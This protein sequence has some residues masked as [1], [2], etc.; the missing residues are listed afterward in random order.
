MRLSSNF[1]TAITEPSHFFGRGALLK[2]V[3]ADPFRVRIL[4]GGRRV[5]KTSTLRA[6]EWTMLD[7]DVNQQARAFPVFIDLKVEQPQNLDNFRYLLIVRLREALKKWRQIPGQFFRDKYREFL[8]QISAAELTV[9]FPLTISTKINVINPDNNQKLENDDFRNAFLQTID[10]LRKFKF[11]GV[12]FLIDEAEFVVS[13][14]WANDAW[15]Y[16]RGLKDSDMAIHPFLGLVISGYRA[17]NAYQQDVSSP[18][19]NIADLEWLSVLTEEEIQKLIERRSRDEKL[20]LIQVS[21]TLIEY[22]GCHPY[23]T[24]QLINAICDN[25][26]RQKFKKFEDLLLSLIKANSFD[27]S[28]WWNDKDSESFTQSEKDIYKTLIN[29][30]YGTVREIAFQ[31]HMGV[32][33]TL[34]SL[35]ILSGAGVIRQRSDSDHYMIGAKM[36]ESWVSYQMQ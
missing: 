10:E 23:L 4:L 28:I 7:Y 9:N 17:L 34:G 6:L 31:A 29:C 18:L 26:R 12:C 11:E 32:L 24:N 33:E 15:S 35:E 30:R 13:Q 27:F 14:S 21:D 25:H 8:R 19:Y 36:F 5:G 1:K 16:F 22:A 2:N 20:K 3:R